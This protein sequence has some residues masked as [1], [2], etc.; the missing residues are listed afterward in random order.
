[1]ESLEHPLKLLQMTK[2]DTLDLLKPGDQGVIHAYAGHSA[3]HARL[4]E[5]GMI[6]GTRV[7]VKRF[8]PFGDP[9]ELIVRGYRL[10]VR[11]ADAARILIAQRA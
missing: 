6:E 3:V 4:R 5:M 7:E 8:A 9:I 10:C 11:R 1:M 2:F